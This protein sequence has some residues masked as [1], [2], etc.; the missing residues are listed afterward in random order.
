MALVIWGLIAQVSSNNMERLFKIL[1]A[2]LPASVCDSAKLPKR[3][4]TA[5]KYMAAAE[6]VYRGE[7]D[8]GFL[9]FNVPI[10]EDVLRSKRLKSVVVVRRS[11]R[12]TASRICQNPKNEPGSLRTCGIATPGVF[13]DV[14]NSTM[15]LR[16]QDLSRHFWEHSG[17]PADQQLTLYAIRSKDGT[18]ITRGASMPVEASTMTLA[19]LVRDDRNSNGNVKLLSVYRTPKL[20]NP[21]VASQKKSNA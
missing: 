1:H 7:E 14:M 4:A 15:L 6:T 8:R 11:I 21:T 10:T 19:N 18:A 12:E 5:V 2:L 17:V 20:H 16:I 3:H 9:H 13:G